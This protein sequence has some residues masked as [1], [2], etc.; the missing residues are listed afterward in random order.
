MGLKEWIFVGVGGLLILGS[1]MFVLTQNAA[2]PPPSTQPGQTPG[3]TPP[4]VV[5]AK[6]P[7]YTQGDSVC[8]FCCGISSTNT[9]QHGYLETNG[10]DHR[11][12]NCHF[13]NAWNNG[14]QPPGG[15]IRTTNVYLGTADPY[16]SSM[17]W[18]GNDA[19]TNPVDDTTYLKYCD[20]TVQKYVSPTNK[21]FYA[22][23]EA[24]N[25]ETTP[26]SQGWYWT[27]YNTTDA[28]TEKINSHCCPKITK[29]EESNKPV[30]NE[31]S[32]GEMWL[33][34]WSRHPSVCWADAS[35]NGQWHELNLGVG[36]GL[37]ADNTSSCT[38]HS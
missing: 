25:N 36:E 19:G 31:A 2:Q 5:P 37:P 9:G 6:C 8:P 13:V 22:C 10:A 38:Q 27:K 18:T 16:K 32:A 29:S 20:P 17:Y 34:T 11:C 3:G 35:G 26:A 12:T 1:I 23:C 7:E 15:P 33:D 28:Q 14:S 4:V 30:C 21:A 24:F